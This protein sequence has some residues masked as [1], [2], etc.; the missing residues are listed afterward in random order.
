MPATG[1]RTSSSLIWGSASGRLR[2]RSRLRRRRR[3]PPLPAWSS[4][5]PPWLPLSPPPWPPLSPPLWRCRDCCLPDWLFLRSPR[6]L[7]P[8][9]SSALSSRSLSDRALPWAGVS[10]SSSE[11]ESVCAEGS[12]TAGLEFWGALVGRGTGRRRLGGVALGRLDRFDQRALSHPAGA[13]DAEAASDLLQLG[14]HL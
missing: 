3:R 12:A 7:S 8:R 1:R 5:P 4:P 14:K 6:W 13:L 10:A 9:E 11:L 2:L